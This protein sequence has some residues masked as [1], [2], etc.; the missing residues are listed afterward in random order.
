L[1][2]K[3]DPGNGIGFV[4]FVQN[5]WECPQENEKMTKNEADELLKSQ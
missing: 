4:Q 1:Y 5:L 3:K 2:K